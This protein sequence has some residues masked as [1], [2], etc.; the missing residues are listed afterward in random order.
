MNGLNRVIQEDCRA[1]AGRL[2]EA[3]A[4]LSGSTMLV[5]GAAG[6]LCSYLLDVIAAL[7]RTLP[8]PCRVIAVDNFRIGIP[9]RISH[10]RADAN[11]RF[12]DCD[13]SKGFDPGCPVDWIVH[14]ASI[15]SPTFYR[16]Y[17]LETIDV[18]VNGTRNMLELA[19]KGS[20]GML[21]TSTSE[22]YGDPDPANIPTKEDYRGL[23]SCTGPR[24]CYD[25]SK[26]LGETLSVT[27][28]RLFQTPVKTVRLFNVFGPGQ[29]L[30]DKRII[31]D[32]MS[33]ALASRPIVL[34]SNGLA[35][36]SFCY[37]TDAIAGM[38]LV[39][40]SGSPGEAFNVGNGSEEISIRGLAEFVGEIANVDVSFGESEDRDYVTDNPQRR[41]PDTTKL[42]KQLGWLPMTSLRDGLRRTLDAYRAEGAA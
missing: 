28:Y 19:K 18:N 34:L 41:C 42:Q 6:F 37:I 8:A 23:V 31:P 40:I 38:L 9:E 2:G 20:R 15:G 5:T 27:Y 17:P 39:L 32:L 22:I 1:V 4:E 24:A 30:D 35:T 33:A 12:E 3:A 7:N 11:F 36:R 25:E 26:R 13:V 14:G 21:L 16:R 29:R 10:L